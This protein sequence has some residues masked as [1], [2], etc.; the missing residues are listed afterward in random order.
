MSHKFKLGTLALSVSLAL[1]TT[2]AFAA[3]EDEATDDNE[4]VVVLGSRAAP[5]S[6]SDSPVPIDLIGGEDFVQS[7][8][9]NLLDTMST[10]VPSFNVNTQ[11][12]SDAATMMRPANMR[13]L[14]PDSTLVL[15]NGKR[16][17]RGAVI[18]FLGAGLSD[19]SQGPDISVIPSMALQQVEV[20]R[21]GA[22]A[23]Y[24]SDAIAG[25][26]NFVLK[27][28]NDGGTIQARIGQYKEGDGDSVRV[29]GNFGVPITENGFA[30]ITYEFSESDATSRSVQRDD[31]AGLIAAGNT[32]VANPAQIW[33]SPEITDDIKLFGNFG[34]DLEGDG[35]VYMHANYAERH[36]EGGFF[37]RNPTNRGGVFDGPLLDGQGGRLLE[38]NPDGSFV[39]TILVGDETAGATN[40]SNCPI[41]RLSPSGIPDAS[42]LGSLAASNCFAFN[43]MFP[44]GF[45]P[46]F[47]GD[48]NDTAVTAGFKGYFSN[49]ISYD[50]SGSVGRS[51]AKFMIFNTIN[52]SLG[53]RTP[54]EFNPGTYIELD[55]SINAD[56]TQ[57][58]TIDGW[59]YPLNLAYGYEYKNDSFEIK[60]GDPASF[61][62]G[63]L[64]LQGFGV[65]SNG[66]G[67]FPPTA[68][69][70]SSRHNNALY[71][72]A[73]AQ[74]T[75]D[76]L[77]GGAVRAEKYSDFGS[78]TDFKLTTQI[79]ITD[80]VSFRG[81]VSTGFRAPTIGQSNVRNVTTAFTGGVLADEATLPPTDP[82]SAYFGGTALQPEESEA[83]SFGFVAEIDDFF[84][85]IDFYRIDVSGRI[86]TSSKFTLD[87][88]D[89]AI[90]DAQGVPNVLSLSSLRYFTNAFDTRTE[91]IDLVMNY[92]LGDMFGGDT[93]LGFVSSYTMTDVTAFDPTVI[94]ST[95]KF[96]LESTLPKYRS[97]LSVNHKQDDWSINARLNYYGAFTETHLDEFAWLIEAD[98]EVT[99]DLAFNYD[100]SSSFSV[101]VGAQNIF[102][103]YPQ[104]NLDYDTEIVGA[105][106]SLTSPMGFNGA[107]YYA[108]ATY[109]Y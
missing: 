61:A 103:E 28:D 22:A 9:G 96:Q 26:I 59:D 109:T 101:T 70:Q 1:A 47:G 57:E 18:S 51:E 62:Q 64:Y 90:L 50:F 85:T 44:G 76:V 37:F 40:N 107:Y 80:E 106:Y 43:L 25:V 78:T 45:T 63:P 34:I 95:R 73:E 77:I 104:E 55:K 33:G 67:G 48:V 23:Q 81:S 7:P 105:K 87:A 10:L 3:E 4:R 60:T 65:G 42:A 29:S 38:T 54:T 53:S 21:D 2:T 82:A 69:G 8:S 5:R 58:V 32:N 97:T 74:V 72:D 56:F 83:I 71:F 36:V 41:V 16:R 49:G 84:G 14:P 99:V 100:I 11:P 66:F 93:T 6:V 94:S 68:A 92:S 108:E 13:G 52:A 39:D 24:G 12:I 31:A 79:A 30:N 91:G 35:Q 15:V 89:Q 27:D 98:A 75:E 17:H 19:G 46:R 88:T 102:D 20:L 86:G